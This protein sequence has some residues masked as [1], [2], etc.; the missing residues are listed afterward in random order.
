MSKLSK[1]SSK[2]AD[3]ADACW[4]YDGADGVRLPASCQTN[5]AGKKSRKKKGKK[6]GK[7]RK[8]KVCGY[9]HLVRLVQQEKKASSN[10]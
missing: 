8:K 3:G 10:S 2:G 9:R 5:A 4:P 6:Q 7:S 1:G